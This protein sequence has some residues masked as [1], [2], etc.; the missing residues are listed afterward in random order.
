MKEWL[1]FHEKTLSRGQHHCDSYN[2]YAYLAAQTSFRC[3]NNAVTT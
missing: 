3:L 2:L 1:A